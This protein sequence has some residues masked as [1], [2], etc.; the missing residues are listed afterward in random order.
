M[1]FPPC[2]DRV[3]GLYV[4]NNGT[5]GSTPDVRIRGTI[6]IGQVHPLYVVDGNFQENQLSQSE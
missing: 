1:R 6:S 4:V 3:T 5:P 2:K